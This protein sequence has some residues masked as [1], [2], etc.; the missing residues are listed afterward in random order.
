MNRP[1]QVA[2]NKDTAHFRASQLNGALFFT[3]CLTWAVVL[4]RLWL[5]GLIF[6]RSSQIPESILVLAALATTLVSTSAHLPRQNVLLAA[7]IIGFVGTLAA[8]LGTRL[9]IPFGPFIFAE[10]FAPKILNLVPWAVPF[11]WVIFILLARGVGRLILRPWRKS[12]TYG[13][14]LIAVTIGMVVLM[15]LAFE[16]Y[17]GRVLHLWFWAPSKAGLFWYG[18]PWTNFIGWG[19]ITSLILAF[20]T[21]A[22]MNKRPAK[23]PP[24]IQPLYVWL[25]I[26]ALFLCASLTQHFW[27][28]AGLTAGMMATGATL[29]FHGANW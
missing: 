7:V 26:T 27:A 23:R 6:P 22:L 17:A 2:S 4:G 10:A 20:I 14:R 16:P 19:V 21:P 15:D 11:L 13:Y 24:D 1:T 3:F 12:R 28:A 5:P 8:G 9:G 18:C 25:L 29:A